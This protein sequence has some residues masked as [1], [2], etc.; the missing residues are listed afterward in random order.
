MFKLT[1]IDFLKVLPLILLSLFAQT[2][3]TSAS[4]VEEFEKGLSE[5]VKSKKIDAYYLE[6]R[7]RVYSHLWFENT[8]IY[9]Y[10]NNF[11]ACEEIRRFAENSNP[12]LTFRCRSALQ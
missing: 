2:Q 8:L 7:G 11:S 1:K 4:N 9:G 12:S 10:P 5:L 6:V 3:T